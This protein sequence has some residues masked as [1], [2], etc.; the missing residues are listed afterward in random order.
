M[1]FF[2]FEDA[3]EY[4]LTAAYL[5]TAAHGRSAAAR[6]RSLPSIC[7]SEGRDGRSI[8]YRR[9]SSGAFASF[10]LGLA[11]GLHRLHRSVANTFNRLTLSIAW[12]LLASL[13]NEHL[14]RPLRL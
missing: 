6:I 4:R 14:R 7:R 10:E 1:R 12:P 2:S 9:L 5:F 8:H 11:A 3:R 13:P